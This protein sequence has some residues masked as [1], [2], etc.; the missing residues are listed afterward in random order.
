MVRDLTILHTNDI[1]GRVE[2]IAR[3]ATIVEQARAASDRAVLYL[4]AGDVEET[5]T[6]LSNVTKGAAMHR[7]LSAAG[8]DA[9]TIGNAAWLRY[10][11]GVVAEHAKAANYPLLVANMRPVPGAQDAALLEADGRTIG[12]VGITAS[13]AEMFDF[14]FGVELLDEVEVVRRLAQALRGRGADL[15]VV[16]SHLG[17]EVPAAAVDDRRLARELDGEVDLI[18]GAHSHDLLPEG[19]WI[20]NVLVVQA[21]EYAQHVGRVE[22]VDGA[23]R[24]SVLAVA[25][26]VRPHDAVLAEIE[27]AERDADAL[28]DEVIGE[29]P[30]AL[31][32]A[33]AAA[34]FADI[35][36]ERM[37]ADVAVVTEGQAFD[38]GLPGGPLRR[39]DLWDVCHSSANPAVTQMTGEQLTQLLALGRDP[40]F[41]RTTPRPLRGRPRGMLQVSA[42]CELEAGRVYSVAG[43]DWELEPYGGMVPSEWSLEVRYDFPTIVREA[44]EEHL[45]G[46]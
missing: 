5:T 8:C 25:D 23:F 19:E 7:L 3:V 10:G 17:L 22:I 36:R 12:V 32:Q 6:P 45:A 2:G 31:D 35:L 30:A 28:L 18:V 24:A 29:L 37:R 9:A 20:G 44:I 34:W 4:D 15:I 13:L 46:R 33:G 41:A 38:G 42:A 11:P 43:T 27:R 16:L 40:D 14:D 26:D 39:R 21:G 1:H